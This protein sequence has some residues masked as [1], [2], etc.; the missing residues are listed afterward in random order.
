MTHVKTWTL[1]L[2]FCHFKVVAI[3]GAHS[4]GQAIQKS[5]GYNGK[6]NPGHIDVFNNHYY[7]AMLDPTLHWE[8]KASIYFSKV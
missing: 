6:W 3:L 2:A 8:N 4:V 7:E 1:F 5:S